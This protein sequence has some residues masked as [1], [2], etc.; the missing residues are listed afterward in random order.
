[1]PGTFSGNGSVRWVI[2]ARRVKGKPTSE[3]KGGNRH[4]QEGHDETDANGT[5]E[6]TIKYPKDATRRDAFRKELA[7]AAADTTSNVLTLKIPIEDTVSGY[8]PPT[9]EQI[10][11]D[12]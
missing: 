8:N 7:R 11:I 3:A 6:V 2:E 1:M 9:D 12:W 4:Y 10:K 5:F